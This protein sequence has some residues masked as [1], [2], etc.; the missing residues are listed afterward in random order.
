[1]KNFF[2][3]NSL[4]NKSVG[5]S[6][7]EIEQAIIEG[8]YIAFNEKREFTENDIVSGLNSIIPLSKTHPDK[9][10]ENQNL[11]LSGKI[12]IASQIEKK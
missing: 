2:D 1:M 3:F 11:A 12:R 5:F 6:G 10:L 7:A 9:L 4:S 8:M